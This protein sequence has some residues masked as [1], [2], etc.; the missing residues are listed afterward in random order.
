MTFIELQIP[1]VFLIEMRPRREDGALSATAYSSVEFERH[2]LNPRVAQCNVAFNHRRGTVRGMHYQAEPAPETKLVR[3]TRGGIYDV[4][5]DM[6]PGSPTF[7]RHVGVELNEDNRLSLYVPELCAHGYQTLTDGT[8]VTYQVSEYHSPSCERGHRY[9]D[10]QFGI[11]WPLP[12]T[13]ISLKDTSWPLLPDP[14][15]SLQ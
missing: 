9:D 1:G 15:A 7:L 5:I 3:C 2:G 4:V 10:P 6:R 12:T 11:A 13:E 8:E 14:V